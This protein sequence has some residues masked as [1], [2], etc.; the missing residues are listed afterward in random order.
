MKNLFKNQGYSVL[1]LSTV[2][3]VMGGGGVN[4]L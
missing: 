4:K 3:L 1:L 2:V